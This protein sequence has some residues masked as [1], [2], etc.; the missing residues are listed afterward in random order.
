M[1]FPII[2][3]ALHYIGPAFSWE[4][5]TI[6]IVLK[7]IFRLRRATRFGCPPPP[8]K[9]GT[10]GDQNGLEGNFINFHFFVSIYQRYHRK[11]DCENCNR[12][13]K[14]RCQ[15]VFIQLRTKVF[16]MEACLLIHSPGDIILF[17]LRVTL[18]LK[19]S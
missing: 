3:P 2:S 5:P 19:N 6:D 14:T 10:Q 12:T 16:S 18:S 11:K 17:N 9:G 15:E 1:I 13:P 4:A 7:K 8:L